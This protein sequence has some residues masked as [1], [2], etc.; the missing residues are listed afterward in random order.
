M[1]Y[2][3]GLKPSTALH[4]INNKWKQIVFVGLLQLVNSLLKHM[5][6]QRWD[7]L[8][9]KIQLL[10]PSQNCSVS[11]FCYHNIL[12]RENRDYKSS[13]HI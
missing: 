12:N 9:I 2:R 5:M 11:F 4:V 6:N 1:Y 10:P 8:C 7:I 3:R 13:V